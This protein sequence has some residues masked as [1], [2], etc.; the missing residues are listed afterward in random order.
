MCNHIWSVK[1]PPLLFAALVVEHVRAIT[2]RI[3]DADR[4]PEVATQ[5]ERA[6]ANQS[7]PRSA[8]WKRSTAKP[9]PSARAA[10]PVRSTMA[11]VTPRTEHER[12]RFMEEHE[13][14]VY[15]A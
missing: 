2:P 6:F 8:G 13:Q 4:G 5:V 11:A 9:G 7:L 12:P 3:G 1:H 15:S 14:S 10:D